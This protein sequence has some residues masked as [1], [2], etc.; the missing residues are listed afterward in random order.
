MFCLMCY[1]ALGK[2]AGQQALEEWAHALRLSAIKG[3]LICSVLGLFIGSL[4]YLLFVSRPENWHRVIKPENRSRKMFGFAPITQAE[5]F[6]PYLAYVAGIVLATT[7][8]FIVMPHLDSTKILILKPLK[9][10]IVAVL[11]EAGIITVPILGFSIVIYSKIT[12]GK[13]K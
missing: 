5:A 8:V 9:E 4:C 3:A 2:D 13:R 12:G 6:V 7:F 10:I 11:I 1:K